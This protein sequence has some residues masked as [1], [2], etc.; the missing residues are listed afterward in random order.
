M[1][2]LLIFALPMLATLPIAILI[3][4]F[5]IARKKTVSYGTMFAAACSIPLFLALIATILQ[6]DVWWSREDK[7]T[8]EIFITMLGF[9]AGIC[10]LPALGVVV[11]YQRRSKIG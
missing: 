3:C 10:V 11:Y 1:D 4:R 8:P 9:I 5:R 7:M 6:P 2:I